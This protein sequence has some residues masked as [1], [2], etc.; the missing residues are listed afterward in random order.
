MKLYFVFRSSDSSL[1]W[2]F[3]LCITTMKQKR[4]QLCSFMS[5]LTFSALKEETVICS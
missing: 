2:A 1:S 4:C 3:M 5:E